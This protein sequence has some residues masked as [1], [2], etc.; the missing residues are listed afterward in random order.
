VECVVLPQAHDHS[1]WYVATAPA[2]GRMTADTTG[3][4]YDTV[5]LALTGT[6]GELTTVACS[7]DGGSDRA[8]LDFPVTAGTEYLFEATSY[9]NSHPGELQLAVSFRPCGNGVLDAG[10][11]CEPA[12]A[13]SCAVGSCAEDCTCLVPVADE[14]TAAVAV[15][16]PID[17]RLA[18]DT[19]TAGALDPQSAC[20]DNPPI[21]PSSVWFRF[22]AP[23]DGVVGIDTGGSDYDTVLAVF[24]GDC[25]ALEESTCDD[26]YDSVLLTSRVSVPVTAGVTYTILVTPYFDHLAGRLHLHAAYER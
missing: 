6:C 24:G 17:V 11:E 3:S 8:R 14:C 20:G 7:D 13:G 23:D 2:V 15:A 9:R 19:A 1:V 18:A 26:D 22:V 5:L 25:A 4:T 16:L 12:V 10:E 21:P